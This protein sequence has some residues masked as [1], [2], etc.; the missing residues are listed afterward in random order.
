MGGCIYQCGCCYCSHRV[1]SVANVP[2]FQRFDGT[3]TL[4]D[5]KFVRQETLSPAN[6]HARCCWYPSFGDMFLIDLFVTCFIPSIWRRMCSFCRLPSLRSFIAAGNEPGFT[7]WNLASL[8]NAEGLHLPCAL[9]GNGGNRGDFATWWP[10]T[11][12]FMW[13]CRMIG[14]FWITLML[15]CTKTP[16]MFCSSKRLHPMIE[17][18][19]PGGESQR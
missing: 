17:A 3:F 19:F 13:I 12:H 8:S 1:D 15:S 18:F 11:F 7:C 10:E 4:Q 6:K 9:V 2:S 5:L 14:I 16:S